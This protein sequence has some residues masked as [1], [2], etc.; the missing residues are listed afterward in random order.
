MAKN[1]VDSFENFD[2]V[3][4]ESYHND[5]NWWDTK[6][7]KSF[8]DA[9]KLVI[10]NHYNESDCDGVYAWYKSFYH[11]EKLSFICE[12]VATKKYKHYNQ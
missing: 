5:K 9:G 12:D 4:Y 11:T 7:T 2:G 10:I 6:G 8:L 3:L 1:T